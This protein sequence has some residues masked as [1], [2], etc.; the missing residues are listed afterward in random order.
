MHICKFFMHADHRRRAFWKTSCVEKAKVSV[1]VLSYAYSKI[2]H[3]NI[4]VNHIV[5]KIDPGTV[6]LYLAH[7]HLSYDFGNICSL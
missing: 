5:Q 2:D 3:S 4:T 1:T 7:I 6:L